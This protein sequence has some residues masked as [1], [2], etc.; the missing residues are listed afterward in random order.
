MTF[1]D[2]YHHNDAYTYDGYFQQVMIWISLYIIIVLV[3]FL[4]ENLI[5]FHQTAFAAIFLKLSNEL[6]ADFW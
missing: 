3:A 5:S 1:E 4:F 6:V 2:E